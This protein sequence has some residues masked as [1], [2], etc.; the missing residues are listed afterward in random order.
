MTV[1]L[2]DVRSAVQPE[3]ADQD[4]EIYVGLIMSHALAA[5]QMVEMVKLEN[6]R[7]VLLSVE[8]T[9][10]FPAGAQVVIVVDFW[11]L[12]TPVSEYLNAFSRASP[13]VTFLALD[14]PSSDVEIA[15]LLR[16]GFAGFITYDQSFHF[17]G[18][19][20]KAVAQGQIWAS[21]EALRIYV[22]LTSP[23]NNIRATGIATLTVRENQILDLLRRR[24]SN[25]EIANHFGISESTVKFHVSN[26]LTKLNVNGRRDVKDKEYL[27]S[28]NLLFSSMAYRHSSCGHQDHRHSSIG[29]QSENLDS[30]D[31]TIGP[32]KSKMG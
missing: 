11:G 7:P 16:V 32:G 4:Q 15:Q 28:T 5:R 18:P 30:T 26:V 3:L 29:I 31:R 13:Q 27:S 23:R 24:L 21:P 10:H 22:N 8:N 19:A 14:Q 25:R 20:I 9:G 17:L 1:K 2:S 6:M 12:P